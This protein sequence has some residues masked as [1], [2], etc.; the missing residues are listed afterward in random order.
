MVGT[1]FLNRSVNRKY[2]SDDNGN[3]NHISI[4]WYDDKGL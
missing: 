2:F 4:I 3:M 1:K